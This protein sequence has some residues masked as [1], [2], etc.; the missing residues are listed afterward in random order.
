[1]L[2]AGQVLMHSRK[3]RWS[4]PSSETNAV[5]LKIFCRTRIFCND[6]LLYHMRDMIKT[7]HGEDKDSRAMSDAFNAEDSTRLGGRD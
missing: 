5:G 3:F 7:H 4:I 1:M 2:N 6:I